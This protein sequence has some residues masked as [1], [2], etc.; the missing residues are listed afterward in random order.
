MLDDAMPNDTQSLVRGPGSCI[1][2][3][4][5]IKLDFSQESGVNDLNSL[6]S[7]RKRENYQFL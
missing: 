3:V 6:N 7:V 1:E 2:L 5:D 4:E